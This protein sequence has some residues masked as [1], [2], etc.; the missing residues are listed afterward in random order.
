MEKKRDGRASSPCE[1]LLDAVKTSTGPA[2]KAIGRR[3]IPPGR[4]AAASPAH[5]S[6]Q[7]VFRNITITAVETGE[8][9]DDKVQ[10][11]NDDQVPIIK[12][13]KI[14]Q[15][16][17]PA[18]MTNRSV[19]GLDKIEPKGQLRGEEV[20][21]GT[22]KAKLGLYEEAASVTRGGK[23]SD[24]KVPIGEGTNH[25]GS[26]GYHI[27]NQFSAYIEQ[28]RLKIRSYSNVGGGGRSK[29]VES[30]KEKGEVAGKTD[31]HFTNYINKVKEKMINAS[32]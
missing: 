13:A 25:K 18:L 9:K 28:T 8:E 6:P 21:R 12:S 7:A 4:R 19:S 14:A 24:P 15:A 11:N 27:E 23:K 26:A 1:R 10:Y 29:N 22:T 31:E 3:M 32:S 17:E 2:F 16:A 30:G 5:P 20:T